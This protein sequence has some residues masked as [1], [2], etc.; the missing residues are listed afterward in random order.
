METSNNLRFSLACV[1]LRENP[2]NQSF[3][4]FAFLPFHFG[5][6]DS[7]AQ[8]L[9]L[10]S[11]CLNQK[12]A[13]QKDTQGGETAKMETEQMETEQTDMLHKEM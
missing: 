1:K 10:K 11:S 6:S 5:V 12:E 3:T 7:L 8:T 2:E 4:F 13:Q 9:S